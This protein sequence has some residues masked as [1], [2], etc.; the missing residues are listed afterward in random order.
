MPGRPRMLARV[1]VWRT[2]TAQCD[3]TLLTRPKMDPL[4][5]DLHALGTFANLRLLHGL[6]G[7][8]MTTT[9]IGHNYFRLLVEASRR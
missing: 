6:D 9:T 1:F 7:V 5:A 4:R 8:E 2:V 3:S